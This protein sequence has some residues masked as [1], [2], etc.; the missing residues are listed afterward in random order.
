MARELK[1]SLRIS[2][3]TR[4]ALRGLAALVSRLGARA[5]QHAEPALLA[6]LASREPGDMTGA[7]HV[8]EIGGR[9]CAGCMS[10]SPQS[11]RLVPAPVA[12]D[13]GCGGILS[14]VL[15]RCNGH[16]GTAQGPFSGRFEAPQ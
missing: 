11:C 8:A 7:S 14:P 13:A 3:Q 1:L 6:A 2:A 4:E 16:A 12:S 15:V 9:A 5:A 10:L